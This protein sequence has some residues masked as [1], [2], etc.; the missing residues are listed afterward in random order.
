MTDDFSSHLATTLSA[1]DGNGSINYRNTADIVRLLILPSSVVLI[2]VFI[3]LGVLIHWFVTSWC[4][5]T[6]DTATPASSVGSN[7]NQESSSSARTPLLQ[8]AGRRRSCGAI[9]A[10]LVFFALVAILGLIF[11]AVG[12]K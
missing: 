12:G 11:A 6:R 2:A 1:A 10:P 9:A 3:A 7:S 4:C 5:C 8:P